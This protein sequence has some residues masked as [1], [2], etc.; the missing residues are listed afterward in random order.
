MGFNSAFKGLKTRRQVP[1]FRLNI[2]YTVHNQIIFVI[3]STYWTWV[4]FIGRLSNPKQ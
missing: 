3:L 2:D 4:K 1:F